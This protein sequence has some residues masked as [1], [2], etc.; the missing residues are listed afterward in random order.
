VNT[1]HPKVCP[2]CGAPIAGLE[3][4]YDNPEHYDG[5]SEWICT[6]G[7]DDGSWHFRL[8]RW[9]GRLLK[10]NELEPPYGESHGKVIKP[11]TND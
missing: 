2:V 5:V 7:A 1:T 9:T 8:G 6:K 11:R 10:K 4:G 3:Y